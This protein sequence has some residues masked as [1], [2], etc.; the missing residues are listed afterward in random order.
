MDVQ[1]ERVRALAVLGLGSDASTADVDAA[2]RRLVR[3]YH[4]DRTG[5]AG[6]TEQLSVVVE[7]HRILQTKVVSAGAGPPSSVPPA[8]RQGARPAPRADTS[9]IVAG[10]VHYTPVPWQR[11]TR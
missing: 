6:S 10:P 2:Y 5:T 11:K 7:A 4:P 8:Q 9:P 3:R 1:S